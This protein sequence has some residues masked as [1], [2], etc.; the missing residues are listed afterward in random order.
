V[1]LVIDVPFYREGLAA[2]LSQ[3]ADVVIAGSAQTAESAALLIGSANPDVL[4]VDTSAADAQSLCR[5]E[6]APPVV[7]LAVNETPESVAAWAT[8]GAIGYVSRSAGLADLLQC[9]KSAARGEVYCSPRVMSI[10]L[11]RYATQSAALAPRGDDLT[12]R[13]REILELVGQ[14]LCN[15]VIATRLHISHATAKNHVHHILDKLQLRSR[16]EAAAYLHTQPDSKMAA[17]RIRT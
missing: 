5:L 2:L 4:L 3:S 10:L 17:P 1:L 13:E 12:A 16:A 7:A 15:K 11:H 6:D 14:G 8:A 9:L